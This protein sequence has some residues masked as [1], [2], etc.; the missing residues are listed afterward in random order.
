MKNMISKQ[1]KYLPVWL[2]ISNK[3]ILIIGGGRI[4][5]QKLSA[6]SMFTDKITVLSVEICEDIQQTSFGQ[7]T[8]EYQPRDLHHYSIVYACTNN[9]TVNAQIKADAAKLNIL[10]NV[11]DD[12]VLCDFITPAIFIK[13]FM[14]VAV[15]S[16]GVNVK[17]AIEWRN[18]I[19]HLMEN[20]TD[21][22]N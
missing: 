18:K 17:K 10:V 8:K 1:R 2:D 9:R 6:L 19:K 4:A 7:I 22:K 20:D 13:D 12:P 15:S 11:V 16:N 14:T 21:E 3:N 5:T